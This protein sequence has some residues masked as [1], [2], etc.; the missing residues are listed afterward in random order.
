MGYGKNSSGETMRSQTDVIMNYLITTGFSISQEECTRMF[1]FT[2]LAARMFD[3]KER[4]EK[5][6]EPYVVC[7]KIQHGTNRY[8]IDCKWKEWWIVKKD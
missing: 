6:D 8:G 4:I 1:G 3:I 2:R 5:K 7:S